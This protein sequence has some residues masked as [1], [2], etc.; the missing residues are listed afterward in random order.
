[1]HVV[2]IHGWQK[3]EADVAQTIA[4]ALGILLFEARQRTAGGGP[5]VL[6]SYADPQQAEALAARLSREGVPA[7]AIDAAA[8]RGGGGRFDARRFWLNA[9]TIRIELSNGQAGEIPYREIGLLLAA[10]ATAGRMQSTTTVTERKFSLGKTLLAGG[11][12]MT[13]KVQHEETVT[14]EERD[15]VLCLYAGR[16]PPVLFRRAG[17]SYEG[18]GAAMQLS[19]DLNFSHLKTELR[20]LAPAAVFDDRLLKRAAQ[21]R[22]LGASLDPQTNLDLACEILARSLSSGRR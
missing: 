7:L 17:V 19:R 16:R 6:A 10:T 5:A 13:K 14:S 18:L 9:S 21:A 2:A 8:V 12:P 15:E 22:I 4:D 1:M 11:V 20:R 3:E